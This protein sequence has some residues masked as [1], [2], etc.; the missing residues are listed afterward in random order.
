[1]VTIPRHWWEGTAEDLEAEVAEFQRALEHHRTTVGEAAP[2]HPLQWV[3]ELAKSSVEWRLEPEPEAPR[4]AWAIRKRGAGETVLVR[5]T[6]EGKPVFEGEEL[7]FEDPTGHVL[8]DDGETVRRETAPER[9]ARRRRERWEEFKQERHTLLNVTLTCEFN[10]A[11]W[12][13]REDDQNRLDAAVGALEDAKLL[14]LLPEGIEVPSTIPWRDEANVVHELTPDEGRV[15]SAMMLL[16]QRA[17]WTRS[18]ALDAALQ[19][20]RTV[21]E[22]E[23]LTW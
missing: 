3:E 19:S 1:M 5:E 22:V 20:A 8:D 6:L 4:R 9:L 10:G 16:A 18:W 15:L 12:Q 21:A 14:E 2:L 11:T 23:A 17:V 13:A 7:V